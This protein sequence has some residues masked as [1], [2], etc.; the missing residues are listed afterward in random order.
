VH[1]RQTIL[2]TLKFESELFMLNPE[3][4]QDRRVQVMHIHGIF[5]DVILLDDM[6]LSGGGG[7]RE[8]DNRND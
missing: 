3:Q 6:G 4:M 7:T 2:P 5:G 1:I 8:T